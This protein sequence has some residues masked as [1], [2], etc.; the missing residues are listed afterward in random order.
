MSIINTSSLRIYLNLPRTVHILCL[1]TLINR[2]GGFVVP[3]LTLYMQSRQGGD[4]GFATWAVGAYGAGSLIASLVGGRLADVIGRKR[5]MC[6]AMFGGAAMLLCLCFATSRTM[7]L[8]E[9]FLTALILDMYRPAASAVIAD[10]V[11]P[12]HRPHAFALMYLA[13]NLGF[14]IAP[15]AGG[16]LATYSFTWLFIIDAAGTAAFGLFILLLIS[17]APRATASKPNETEPNESTHATDLRHESFINSLLTVFGDRPFAL[18]CLATFLVSAA[19]AQALSTLPIH[20]IRCGLSPAAFGA[21][22][23]INGALIVI[24]QLPVTSFTARFPRRWVLAVGALFVGAGFSLHTAAP[25]IPLMVLAIMTWTMGEIMA[26][27]VGPARVSDAAPEHLRGQYMGVY[28]FSFMSAVAVGA[29]LGGYV[30][31][32]FGPNS[33]WFGCAAVATLAAFTFYI[34]DPKPAVPNPTTP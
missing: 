18:F 19:Y 12:E 24:L 4:A 29:P 22:I 25:H 5:T 16:F 8:V 6:L 30:L 27:A 10:Y 3:F 14:A 20:L 15:V 11:E 34:S 13:I 26:A 31:D 17:D 32:R 2:A 23:S 7:I 28:A 9:C 21:L 1:G 33:L